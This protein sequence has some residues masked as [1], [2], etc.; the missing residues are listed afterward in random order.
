MSFIKQ[1]EITGHAG[2]VYTC[3]SSDGYVYSGSTDKYVTRWLLDEGV[4][5]KFAIK[6]DHAIYSIALLENDI[7]VAGLS[8]GALHFFDLSSRKE[9]KYFTQHTKAIFSIKY[10]HHRKHVYVG[11]ADGNLSVWNSENPELI[12]NIPIGCGK[13]RSCSVSDKGEHFALACQDGTIRIFE[14]EHFNEL[15]TFD[16]HEK[17]VT[18]VL[19]HPNDTRLLISGGKDALL[20]LWNW[21]KQEELISVVAHT[22]SVY[23]IISVKNGGLIITSS[24]DKNIKVWNSEDLGFVKRLDAKIGGHRHSVNALSKIDEKTFVSCSDDKRIIVW[25]AE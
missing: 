5:D 21:N 10:N 25:E 14:T 2:E 1:K 16:A 4:Q 19:F 11:D 13:I 17:G 7:L 24:R 12:I 18:S 20:K 6:F 22:F 23:D 15:K 8:D 9:I 3:A